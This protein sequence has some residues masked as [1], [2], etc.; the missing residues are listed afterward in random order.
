MCIGW[1]DPSVYHLLPDNGGVHHSGFP[2]VCCQEVLRAAEPR[3]PGLGIR[4][5]RTRCLWTHWKGTYCCHFVI[6]CCVVRIM[7]VHVCVCADNCPVDADC[8]F[9]AD[10]HSLHDLYQR[11][12]EPLF[13]FPPS[14]TLFSPS[15]CSPP[16]YSL[17]TQLDLIVQFALTKTGH[18]PTCSPLMNCAVLVSMAFIPIFPVTL[19]R[20]LTPMQIT[21]TFGYITSH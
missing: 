5:Y 9:G 15:F 20:V 13:H 10:A 21:S 16:P 3:D 1:T 11:S 2:A 19:L 17:P 12:G 8:S 6:C 18:I 4:R 7:C 14:V